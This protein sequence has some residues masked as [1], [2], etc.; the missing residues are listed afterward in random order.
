MGSHHAVA[1]K[2]RTVNAKKRTCEYPLPTDCRVLWIL[3]ESEM[4]V[5][6]AVVFH[7]GYGHTKR[8]AE[9]VAESAERVR[10][11][12]ARARDGGQ[13]DPPGSGPHHRAVENPRPGQRDYL[14]V[15]YLHE[16]LQ[17]S[18]PG[19]RRGYQCSL[20]RQLSVAR[21]DR[22]RFTNSGNK[23][24]NKLQTLVEMVLFAAQHGMIWVGYL[25]HGG[26]NSNNGS[27]DDPNRLD[28]WLGAMAKSNMDQGPDIAPPYSAC[29]LRQRLVSGWLRSPNCMFVDALTA[30]DP[31]PVN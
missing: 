5:R 19:L 12:R 7:S 17:R 6:V 2:H 11:C 16:R 25:G 29:A 31:K 27:P 10:E 23:S 22:R 21:Q 28:S 9:A 1:T 8:Q 4:I 30:V 20:E 13:R 15:A 26:W 14:W 18:V 3:W 24:G